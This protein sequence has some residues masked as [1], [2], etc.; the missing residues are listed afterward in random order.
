[1]LLNELQRQQAEIR[2]LQE[3]IKEMQ[4]AIAHAPEMLQTQAQPSQTS[5]V[6][7]RQQ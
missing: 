5:A 4:A 2:N 1:M 3:Q 6:N 7:G